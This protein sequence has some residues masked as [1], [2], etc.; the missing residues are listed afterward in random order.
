MNER[1]YAS[2]WHALGRLQYVNFELIENLVERG[3][4][5]SSLSKFLESFSPRHL[6]NVLYSIARLHQ[7]CRNRG[8]LNLLGEAFENEGRFLHGLIKELFRKLNELNEQDLSNLSLAMGLVNYKES[9]GVY[10][11]LLNEVERKVHL[12]RFNDQ[13]L[14]NICYG[15]T[16]GGGLDLFQD[17][18][19]FISEVLDPDRSTGYP[20]KTAASLIRCFM[21]ARIRHENA[22][23]ILPLFKSVCRIDSLHDLTPLE[24]RSVLIGLGL[25]RIQDQELWKSI[26][27][28]ILSEEAVHRLT[29][30]DLSVLLYS[31]GKVKYWDPTLVQQ[32]VSRI[33]DQSESELLSKLAV[34][35]CFFGV[36]SLKYR[37]QQFLNILCK[38][39]SDPDLIENYS[40]VQISNFIFSLGQVRH[41][42]P[43]TVNQLLQKGVQIL[44]KF[45]NNALTHLIFGLSMMG[46]NQ[47]LENLVL[48]FQEALLTNRLGS[49]TNSELGMIIYALGVLQ[50][51]VGSQLNELVSEIQQSSRIEEFSMRDRLRIAIS[52]RSLNHPIPAALSQDWIL[53]CEI[54][55]STPHR[56]V[57]DWL[58]TLFQLLSSPSQALPKIKKIISNFEVQKLSDSEISEL[59]ISLGHL[60]QK[61]EKLELL[62]PL[63]E[64]IVVHGF[65]HRLSGD[66]L[67]LATSILRGSQSRNEALIRS[68]AMESSKHFRIPEYNEQVLTGLFYNLSVLQALDQ[69][70]FRRLVEELSSS[71]RRSKYRENHVVKILKGLSLGRWK[72]EFLVR[73]VLNAFLTHELFLTSN[74]IAIILF[75]LVLL[76]CWGSPYIERL[77][78]QIAKESTLERYTFWEI[79]MILYSYGRMMYVDQRVL[80]LLKNELNKERVQTGSNLDLVNVVHGLSQLKVETP[81]VIFAVL[82]EVLKESRCVTY[83]DEELTKLIRC[84][85]H[86]ESIDPS[87]LAGLL[88]QLS[89][90]RMKGM[91]TERILVVLKALGRVRM[92]EGWLLGEM[93]MTL[94]S[95]KRLGGFRM[96]QLYEL[97]Y[98]AGVNGSME[99]S[100]RVKKRIKELG[101]SELSQL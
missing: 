27:Q 91:K 3:M 4:Q 31:M 52:L 23:R 34:A 37:N 46:S 74:A 92:S 93:M 73:S 90:P 101:N 50:P 36:G 56:L 30:F 33:I 10:R 39:A 29:V 21:M 42:S 20:I 16:H 98:L 51:N 100:E 87:Q 78:D 54:D 28:F 94:T 5:D 76:D 66:A 69:A 6:T 22:N 60:L 99:A 70:M 64:D 12:Y 8:G 71:E 44:S 18:S 88:N 84:L 89:G 57:I 68:L 25:F 95:S 61:M 85:C 1:C 97:D 26:N 41:K 45:S 55:D 2:V 63:L 7:L 81:S 96:D 48:I 40:T 38:R 13:D 24:F 79:G 53:D 47:G 32:V 14:A 19:Y 75:N 86:W 59:V 49:Y 62:E 65:L 58:E 77:S 82:S 15:L 35:N 43:E 9:P 67:Y 72:D 83:T 80:E 17:C 11:E